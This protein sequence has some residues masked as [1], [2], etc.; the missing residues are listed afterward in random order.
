M[1]TTCLCLAHRKE[2]CMFVP[3][4]VLDAVHALKANLSLCICVHVRVSID[5]VQMCV[6][7]VRWIIPVSSPSYVAMVQ[8]FPRVR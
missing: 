6:C 2:R 5:H 7:P 4:A 3:D 8:T 1:L